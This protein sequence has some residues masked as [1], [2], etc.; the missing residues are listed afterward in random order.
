MVSVS[1]VH[2]TVSC[3]CVVPCP[4]GNLLAVHSSVCCL[5]SVEPDWS[6]VDCLLQGSLRLLGVDG[7]SAWR[8]VSYISAC[9][10]VLTNDLADVVSALFLVGAS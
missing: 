1:R 10:I 7:R 9:I 6:H 8:E 3:V 4:H 2:E 5:V